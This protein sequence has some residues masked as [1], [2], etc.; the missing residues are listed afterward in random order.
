MFDENGKE[1]QSTAQTLSDA[2]AKWD[3]LGPVESNARQCAFTVLRLTHNLKEC[4]IGNQAPL[5]D[6]ANSEQ[7]LLQLKAIRDTFKINNRMIELCLHKLIDIGLLDGS[8]QV[9]DISAV[10]SKARY[11]LG[12]RGNA[13]SSDE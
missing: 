13:Q 5:Y 8:Y 11:T 1:I 12:R 4:M 9:P 3:T 7:F 6:I 2:T 10:E